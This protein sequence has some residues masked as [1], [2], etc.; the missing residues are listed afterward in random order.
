M[1]SLFKFLLVGVVN[2]L[3]GT[4]VMFLL[5]NALGCSY[6]ISSAAN[7]IAGGIVSF[8]LNKYFTF[9]NK[10]RSFKQAVLF[11][12]SVAGCYFLAYGLAKPIMA[13]LLT[14][15]DISLQENA[16]MLCGMVIYTGLNFLVQK[17]LVFKEKSE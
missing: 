13:K 10:D 16:A 11:V 9:R 4:A 7:Y 3:V 17:F 15:F 14:G 2:T 5:Y 1:K 6:W 8:F 12:L